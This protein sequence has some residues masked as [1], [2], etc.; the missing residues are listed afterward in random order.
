[1]RGKT[2]PK[3]TKKGP[4]RKTGTNSKQVIKKKS[5]RDKG[6]RKEGK[7]RKD[8]TG[9]LWK[10]NGA[11]LHCAGHSRTKRGRGLPEGK[12]K[13]KSGEEGSHATGERLMRKGIT[14]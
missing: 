2:N 10:K 5:P 3:D 8:G 7:K 14:L 12:K 6:G 4:S 13:K 9:G 11:N 1:V